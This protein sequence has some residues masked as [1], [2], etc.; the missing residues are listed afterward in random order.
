MNRDD[1]RQKYKATKVEVIA[2]QEQETE[3]VSGS[4]S[5]RGGFHTVKPGANHFRIAPAHPDTLAFW[6]PFSRSYLPMEVDGDKQGEKKIIRKPVFDARIHSEH[7]RH[8]IVD[9]YIKV[10]NKIAQSLYS[11]KKERYAYL[12]HIYGYRTS[13]S[14]VGGIRPNTTWIVY[15]WDIR[16]TDKGIEFGSLDRLELKTTVKDDMNVLASGEGAIG[17]EPFTDIDEGVP[18]TIKYD[19]GQ[20]VQPK[21]RYRCSF[22]ILG[23]KNYPR[24]LPLPDKQLEEMDSVEPLENIYVNKYTSSDFEM[25][26]QGLRLFDEKHGYGVFEDEGFLEMIAFL[27]DLYPVA[28]DQEE[29]EM[30]EE[31]ET[32]DKYDE[33]N[34]TELKVFIKHNNLNIRVLKKYSDDDLRNLI[35]EEMNAEDDDIEEEEEEEEIE[36]D[37]P[38]EEEEEIE[39]EEE[40]EEV[41]E[42]PKKSGGKKR[43]SLDI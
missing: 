32:G 42:Q 5:R 22:A 15:A 1:Y 3:A 14:F 37:Q 43:P 20:G 25:A 29:E 9:E 23:N 27:S 33:M 30:D 28:D 38:I 41:E 39:D 6:Y 10:A 17:T 34:R 2:N 8:D 4:K 21:D 36:I 7:N 35:R 13:N 24:P 40:E 26:V 16:E 31:E 19:N 12:K 11:D 18:I